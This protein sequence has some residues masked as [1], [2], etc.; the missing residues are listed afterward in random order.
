VIKAQETPFLCGEGD[1]GWKADFDWLITN[2]LI[3]YAVLEGKYDAPAAAANRNGGNNAIHSA[4]FD[5]EPGGTS[6]RRTSRGDLMYRPSAP[7]MSPSMNARIAWTADGA[8]WICREA[9]ACVN[10][11]ASWKERARGT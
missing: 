6:T 3:I 11:N 10:A 2:H 8:A 9:L 1:R 5:C 7:T 4:D